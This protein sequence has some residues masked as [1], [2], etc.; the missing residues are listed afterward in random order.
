[1]KLL[2]GWAAET[3]LAVL[4]V[5][6]CLIAAFAGGFAAFLYCWN[7]YQTLSPHWQ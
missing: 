2:D 7:A 5:A 4:M 3:R 1:M 6:G